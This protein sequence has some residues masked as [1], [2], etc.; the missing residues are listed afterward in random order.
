M[1][2]NGLHYFA[3][4]Y[5]NIQSA[6]ENNPKLLWYHLATIAEISYHALS[7]SDSEPKYIMSRLLAFFP[8]LEPLHVLIGFPRY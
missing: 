6:V 4:F 2:S 1:T 5:L 8:R 3:I 7:Q